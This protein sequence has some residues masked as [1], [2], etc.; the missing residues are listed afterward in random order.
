MRMTPLPIFAALVVCCSVL[1]VQGYSADDKD[2][3]PDKTRLLERIQTY[4]QTLFDK[5]HAARYS[6][7]HPYLREGV[8]FEEW[9]KEMGIADDTDSS[10]RVR[11]INTKIV[12]M[13]F[14]GDMSSKSR[15]GLFRCVFVIEVTYE[16]ESGTK[17]ELLPETW[18]YLGDEWYFTWLSHH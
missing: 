6:M 3:I 5:D 10:G 17:V 11:M 4:H 14:C 8:S 18:D 1:S 12:E 16:D 2:S 15:P 9:K 13:R 7:L